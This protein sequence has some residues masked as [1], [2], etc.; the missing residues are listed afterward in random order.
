MAVDVMEPEAQVGTGPWTRE[1]YHQLIATGHFDGVPVELLEGELVV[2]A[3]IREPHAQ[4][5]DIIAWA[6]DRALLRSFGEVY[7]VRQEKPF[8]A[9]TRSEPEPDIMVIDASAASWRAP[10]HPATAHL[11]VEVA[12]SSLTID[13]G[14]KAR[15]YAAAGA[16][17]YWVVDLRHERVVVHTRPDQQLGPGYADV[18]TVPF[19]AELTVL[20][21]TLRLSEVLS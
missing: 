7:R 14:R 17:L 18:Q 12:D 10:D 4:A 21:I 20:G 13:L 15:V 6:L 1:F 2:V 19:T 5:V 9:S 3:P 11:L 8:A 16:P